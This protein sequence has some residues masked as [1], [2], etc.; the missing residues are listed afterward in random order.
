MSQALPD[1]PI[2]RDTLVFEDLDNTQEVMVTDNADGSSL[3][4]NLIATSILEACDGEHSQQDMV[5][6][7]C[8]A[9]DAEPDIVHKDVASILEEFAIFGLLKNAG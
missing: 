2:R 4:L 8:E 6:M 5:Q 3:S 1:Y 9:L 7:I